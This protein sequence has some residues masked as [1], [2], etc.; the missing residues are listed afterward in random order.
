MIVLKRLK[1]GT[2]DLRLNGFRFKRDFGEAPVLCEVTEEQAKQYAVCF[3]EDV[4]ETP[5]VTKKV[6][7]TSDAK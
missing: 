7:E 5:V 4:V 2:L 6:K 1:E 3:E